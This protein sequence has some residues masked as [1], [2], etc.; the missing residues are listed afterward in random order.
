MT[1]LHERTFGQGLD[2]AERD[3]TIARRCAALAFVQPEHL[4]LNFQAEPADGGGPLSRA[5]AELDRINSFK[6]R[7]TLILVLVVLIVTIGGVIC[8]YYLPP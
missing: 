4:D 8:S 2:D 6:A 3:E 1:K 5:C 7:F